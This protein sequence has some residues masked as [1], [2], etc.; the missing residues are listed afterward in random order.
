[1]TGSQDQFDKAVA[2]LDDLRRFTGTPQVFWHSLLES[3]VTVAGARVGVLM[4]KADEG[5]APWQKVG[6]WPTQGVA[7]NGAQAFASGLDT[8]ANTS[9]LNRE[10]LAVFNNPAQPLAN[11]AGV[12]IRLE[13]ESRPEIWVAAFYLPGCSQAEA[14]GTLKQLRLIANTPSIYQRQLASSQNQQALSHSTAVLDL[15]ALMNAEDRFLAVAM[16]LCNEVAARHKCDRVSLGWIDGGYV[17]LQ[18]ISHTEKFERKMEA[19]KAVEQTMEEAFDQDE[20][21]VVPP[22]PGSAMVTRDHEKFAEGQKVKSLCSVPVRVDGVPAGVLTC[23]RNSDPFEES[24][25]HLLGLC[26]EMVGRRMSELKARDR[27]IGARA[28]AAARQALSK[29]VG[30]RHTWAKVISIALAVALAVLFFG[31]MNYRVKASFILRTDDIAIL[32]APFNGFIESAPTRPGDPVHPKDTLLKLDTR[33]LLLEEAAAKA[34]LDRYTRDAEWSRATNGLAEMRIATAQADQARVRLDSVRYHLG[35]SVLTAPFEGV[36][37]EGDL[38]KRIAAPV[39]QGD[40]LFKIARTDRMYVECEVKETDIHEIR[41]DATGQI[42]FA[43]QPKLKFPIR[44]ER[45]EPVAQ[46]KEQ[47]NIFIV[48]CQIQGRPEE[49]WRPGMTGVAK[50][51]VGRRTIFWVISHRTLDFL[52]MYFWL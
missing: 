49:W 20:I 26:A 8:M 42:A 50:L 39:K 32:S 16:T 6:V 2:D 37:V 29:I 17:R 28:A 25:T 24:E 5:A 34:D 1:M 10:A 27:W 11:D 46:V 18:A 33:D 30:V 22:P 15:L 23:E 40:A 35:Q 45:I 31:R 51:E 4:R 19:I 47:K 21:V 52:R 38:K 44:L 48:R 12:A 14:A 36:V 13:S 43:G 7:G 41:D 3:M 9:A